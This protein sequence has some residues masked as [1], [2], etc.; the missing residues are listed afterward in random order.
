[1]N[2]EEWLNCTSDHEG[3]KCTVLTKTGTSYSGVLTQVL[4]SP[5]FYP[6]IIVQLEDGSLKEFSCNK[7]T[8]IDFNDE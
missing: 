3:Q 8:S 1:M 5:I 6:K 2:S 7:L 4:G